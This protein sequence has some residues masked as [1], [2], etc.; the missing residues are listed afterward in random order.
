MFPFLGA[1]M[2]N[3]KKAST[4]RCLKHISRHKKGDITTLM[5][6]SQLLWKWNYDAPEVKVA[7]YTKVSVAQ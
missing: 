5:C 1:S 6:P 7:T 2:V 4:Q 3:L